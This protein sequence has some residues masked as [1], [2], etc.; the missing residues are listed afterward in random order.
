MIILHL[1]KELSCSFHVIKIDS[2]QEISGFYFEKQ[3]HHH[4]LLKNQQIHGPQNVQKPW[5]VLAHP[6][7]DMMPLQEKKSKTHVISTGNAIVFDLEVH[8]PVIN[9]ATGVSTCIWSQSYSEQLGENRP[10]MSRTY[11]SFSQW[12]FVCFCMQQ[13]AILAKKTA[14][15]TWRCINVGQ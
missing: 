4:S 9:C 2:N 7:L 6:K 5:L 3:K 12:K 13:L 14:T 15:Q 8:V 11:S 1:P 10:L